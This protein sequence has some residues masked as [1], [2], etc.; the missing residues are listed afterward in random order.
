MMTVEFDIEPLPTL[1]TDKLGSI[2]LMNVEFD[3]EP[4]PTLPTDKLMAV[5]LD[6]APYR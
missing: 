5:G 4:L 6:P 1:P 3:I 2:R